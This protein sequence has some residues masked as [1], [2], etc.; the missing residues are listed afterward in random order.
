MWSVSSFVVCSES[1]F[2]PTNYIQLCSSGGL[3]QYEYVSPII[4]HQLS[5]QCIVVWQCKATT[6][7]KCF[8]CKHESG[9]GHFQCTM[10][11]V[12]H[13]ANLDA[14]VEDVSDFNG[15]SSLHHFCFSSKS[16]SDNNVMLF[17]YV[18]IF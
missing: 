7:W 18:Y 1:G 14:L 15:T 9:S 13:A 2:I 5:S 16:K 3:D 4:P 10:I 17:K 12:F 6:L 8:A 11:S